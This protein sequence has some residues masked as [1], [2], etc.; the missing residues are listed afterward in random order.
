MSSKH[1]VV[2]NVFWSLFGGTGQAILALAGLIVLARLLSPEDFGLA[3]ISLMVVRSLNLFCEFLFTEALVQHRTLSD[4]DIDTTFNVSILVAVCLVVVCLTVS[5]KIGRVFDQ[6]EINLLIRWTSLLLLFGAVNG[7]FVG[8]LRRNSNFRELAVVTLVGR[9]IGLLVAIVMAIKSMGVWSLIAQQV[10]GYAAI[11]FMLWSILRWRPS[12]RIS[13]DSLRKLTPFTVSFLGGEIIKLGNER[14]IPLLVGYIFGPLLLGYFNLASRVAETL[15]RLVGVTSHQVTMSIFSKQQQKRGKLVKSIYQATEYVCAIAIPL[16]GG[17][18][19]VA[20]DLVVIVFG[21]KWESAIVLVQFLAIGTMVRLCGNVLNTSLLA[22]GQPKWRTVKYAAEFLVGIGC[23]YAFRHL[24]SVGIG[25][26]IILMNVLTLP[27]L[28]L[29]TRITVNLEPNVLLRVFI[30]PIL[31]MVL[32]VTVIY[33]LN[34]GILLAIPQTMRLFLTIA[35]GI[36]TYSAMLWIM[37]PDL[38]RQ[39][40]APILEFIVRRRS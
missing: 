18:A 12:L 20:P 16:F 19:I 33:C 24:N 39:L 25:L 35:I 6:P 7:I 17:L 21:S 9:S 30:K 15:G 4:K 29:A 40:T 28:V 13:M 14:L 36:A 5:H 26:T 32:M 31:A 23:L 8:L 38:L 2:H 11:S 34:S 27:I 37:A 3:A 1:P 10:V 22:I